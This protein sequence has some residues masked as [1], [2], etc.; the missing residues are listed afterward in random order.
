MNEIEQIKSETE[1]M[2]RAAKTIQRLQ[3][4]VLE[5]QR[6]IR[7][8]KGQQKPVCPDCGKTDSW[9]GLHLCNTPA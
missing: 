5:L 2:R 3:S 6:E 9:L 4:D 8:L 7:N 1:T